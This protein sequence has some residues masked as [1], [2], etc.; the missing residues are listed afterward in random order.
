M[1]RGLDPRIVGPL[2]VLVAHDLRNPL[3]ALHSNVGF[4]ESATEPE[5]QD[6]REALSDIT[7]SCSSLNQIIDNLELLG[8]ANLDEPPKLDRLPL[9]IEELARECIARAESSAASYGT[10]LQLLPTSGTG[11]HVLVH[12]EM[13]GRALGNL[14]F[15]AIQHGSGSAVLVAVRREEQ[16]GVVTITDAGAVLAPSLRDAAFT[17]AGQLVCKGNAEGRY[18]RGLGLFA[19]EVAARLAG[20]ELRCATAD[21]KNVL[22]LWAPLA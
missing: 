11:A 9:R 21:G 13:A 14:L 8:I 19:A 15:N 6:I 2:L 10:E 20:A 5:D 18:S 22:E 3:S 7:V 12:R 17:A 1:A 4:L 16:H